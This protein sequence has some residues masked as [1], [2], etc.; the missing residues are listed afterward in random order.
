LCLKGLVG[1]RSDEWSPELF[2]V[3]RDFVTASMSLLARDLWRWFISS[4][5]NFGGPNASRNLSIST[6]L[7]SLF[8][9]GFLSIPYQH[10][11][12]H[13]VFV[14]SICLRVVFTFLHLFRLTK[15]YHFYLSLQ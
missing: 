15:V 8:E 9:C 11:R 13:W 1:F 10:A 6:R 5:F 3:G 12:C 4:W 2:S 7:S 14:I